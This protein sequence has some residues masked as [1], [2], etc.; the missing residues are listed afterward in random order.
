LLEQTFTTHMPLLM[1]ACVFGLGRRLLEFYSTATYPYHLHWT[2]V[3]R[4]HVP[5]AERCGC[6]Q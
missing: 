3:A 6:H 2:I 4:I 1:A 5:V